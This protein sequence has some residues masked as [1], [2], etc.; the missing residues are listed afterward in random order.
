VQLSERI[1]PAAMTGEELRRLAHKRLPG[2]AA[3]SDGD[4]VLNPEFREA[5]RSNAIKP[6]AVLIPILER[7]EGLSVVLT[8]RH[9]DLKAHSGQVAFPGGKIDA[10]DAGV[11]AAAL[12]EAHEEV[13]LDPA[14]VQVLGRLPDYYSGSGYRIAP[15]VGLVAGEARFIANPAEVDFIFEVPFAF[16]MDKANHRTGSREL[17]GRRRFYLEMPYGEHYIWGVTAGII[18][19]LSDRLFP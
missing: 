9:D 3:A 11:E 10:E 16:L 2:E 6:A 13:G 17:G 7:A 4:F 18:A 8:K 12:R 5:I 15:V 1:D 19:A 14:R